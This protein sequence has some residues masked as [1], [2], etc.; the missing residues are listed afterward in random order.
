MRWK[1]ALGDQTVYLN[2]ALLLNVALDLCVP[3]VSFPCSRQ[4][5]LWKTFFGGIL[6]NDYQPLPGAH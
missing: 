6:E 5:V 1:Q 2:T 4:L 3:S